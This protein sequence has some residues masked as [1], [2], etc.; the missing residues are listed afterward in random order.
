MRL[1]LLLLLPL[2]CEAR[3]TDLRPSAPPVEGID[4]GFID[5]GP[6]PTEDTVVSSG[7]FA[8]RSSYTGAGGASVVLLASGA[9]ELRFDDGFQTSS[10]PGPVVVLTTRPSIGSRID[11]A[12]GDLEIA[13]LNGTSGAQT[14]P[15]PP[16]A[17]DARFAWVFCRPFGV[18]I[19]RAELEEGAR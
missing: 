15:V 10:V 17:L 9:V 2:G 5:I 14:Y 12:A 11:P 18:E 6:A 19:A 8:G 13:A 16:A 1:L 3:F 4:G 7:E